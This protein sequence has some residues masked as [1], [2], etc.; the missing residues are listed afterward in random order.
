MAPP[1]LARLNRWLGHDAY[2][3]DRL[4]EGEAIAMSWLCEMG[5]LHDA[6]AKR[7][8]SVL[9]I[10]FELFLAQPEKGLSAALAHLGVAV[11]P[12][13]VRAIVSGPLM[14]RYAKAPEHAY[15]ADLRRRVL[16]Q[17]DR[18]HGREVRRGM[19]WLGRAAQAY[20]QV[21]EVL[22]AAASVRAPAASAIARAPPSL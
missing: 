2:R 16:A 7:P 22:Q 20:P 9:W 21:R 4:S 10:N 13:E 14:Q 3:L 17:A 15:D 5:A 6:A 8:D 18:E 19:D 11:A 1:R 12:D